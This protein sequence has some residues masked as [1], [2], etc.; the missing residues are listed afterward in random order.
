[1]SVT[2]FLADSGALTLRLSGAWA[3]AFKNF[4]GRDIQVT[5]KTVRGHA[6]ASC[7]L[8]ASMFDE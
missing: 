1:M 4:K 8:P 6:L 7:F 2:G 3:D 5:V